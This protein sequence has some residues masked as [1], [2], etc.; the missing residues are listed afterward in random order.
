[1]WGESLGLPRRVP[2]KDLSH[3]IHGWEV[4]IHTPVGIDQPRI[5]PEGVTLQDECIGRDLN[6]NPHSIDQASADHDVDAGLFPAVGVDHRH[7][8]ESVRCRRRRLLIL[9]LCHGG[10][11]QKGKKCQVDARIP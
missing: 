7:I 6:S 1:M 9:G 10:T 5:Y 8:L 11:R 2:G 4:Q 3:I